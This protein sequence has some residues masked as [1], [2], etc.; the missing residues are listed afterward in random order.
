MVVGDHLG[1]NDHEMTVLDSQR[2]KEQESDGLDRT[3]EISCL[4][5]R[6]KCS[7]SQFEDDTKLCGSVDLLEGREPLQRDLYGLD[8]WD[9]DSCIMF[10]KAKCQVLHLHNKNSMKCYR[11]RTEYLERCLA[12]KDLG[13]LFVSWLNMIQQCAQVV[14]KAKGILACIKH[15]G[16]TGTRAVV[17]PLYS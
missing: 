10:I 5:K 4:F 2:S 13:V 15:S 7:L 17:V 1:H 16:A 14:K 8:Q 9:E 12:E 6:I 11:L 3:S